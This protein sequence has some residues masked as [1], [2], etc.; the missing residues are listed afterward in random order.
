MNEKTVIDSVAL[1][2]PWWHDKNSFPSTKVR[3][4]KRSDYRHVKKTLTEKEAFVIIGPRGV[5][6][7]TTI[8]ELV[9][10]LLGFSDDLDPEKISETMPDENSVNQRRIF[11][12]SFDSVI[13]RKMRLLNLLKIYSRYVLKEDVANLSDTIYV[14]FDE[15][16]NA[17]NWGEQIKEIQD[18]GYPVKFVVTG[19]SSTFMI[20]ECSK[21]ARRV[22][23]HFMLPLKFSDFLTCKIGEPRFSEALRLLKKSREDVIRWFKEKNSRAIHDFFLRSYID[24]SPWRTSIEI[25][26]EEYVT[27]GGYPEL[28][29]I[30]DYLKCNSKLFEAFWL[31]F[32]KDVIRAKGASDPR[33]MTDLAAYIASISSS[34]T[35]YTSLMS[36]SGTASNTGMLKK[37]LHHLEN[38]FLVKESHPYKPNKSKKGHAFKIYL[39]DVSVRNLLTGMMNELLVDSDQQ[40]ALAL[41]TVVFDHMLRLNRKFRETPKVFYWKDSRNKKEVDVVGDFPEAPVPVEVKKSDEPSLSDAEG[42]KL[43]TRE[44][45]VPGLV[46][47]GKKLSLEGDIVFVP[48]W[49]FL[50]IC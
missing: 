10:H 18:L 38:A 26:F 6:K 28:V 31:G 33:G 1:Q 47:C 12:A 22:E 21:A 50:M 35:N 17:D 23:T 29:P 36:H 8:M 41:E 14:F 4:F 39:T 45:K 44:H 49:L 13:L 7:S 37:Y 43:F 27:K 20:D 30:K 16:Q 48:H 24:F 3:P 19:S 11:Y 32:H 5:G 40:Y 2:N 15:I 34:E 46:S 42:L 25:H 9:R